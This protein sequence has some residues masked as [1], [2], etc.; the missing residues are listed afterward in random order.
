MAGFII[1]QP[2]QQ[3]RRA[4]LN[5]G[6]VCQGSM[7]STSSF[8]GLIGAPLVGALS[9]QKGRRF[10]L[11]LGCL[12]GAASFLVL[13]LSNSLVGLWIAL[14]PTALLS[15]NFT[16]TKAVVADLANP[17]DRAG[18]LGK[19]GLAVGLGFMVGP[20]VHPFLSTYTQ[21]GVIAMVLQLVSLL[22]IWK[23]PIKESEPRQEATNNI[24]R[25]LFLGVLTTVWETIKEVFVLAFAA[26]AAA[27]VILCLRFGLSVRSFT[28]LLICFS[29]Y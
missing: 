13:I 4:E 12:S 27:K 14:I 25:S 29:A 5:C 17:E 10:A 26:P 6:P 20:V 24:P 18:V 15:H 1:F 8:L 2:Y 11:M 21:A 23:L 22:A 28:Y 3:T 16:I 19:L 7:T 9:D